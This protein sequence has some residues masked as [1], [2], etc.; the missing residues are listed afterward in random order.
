MQ[1]DS[2]IGS[3]WLCSAPDWAGA[4]AGTGTGVPRVGA[5]TDLIDTCS[6]RDC[7]RIR[8]IGCKALVAMRKKLNVLII[9][10]DIT[11]R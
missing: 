6:K 7:R 10:A 2:L 8:C 11:C 9:G 1:A 5:L 4:G 3:P